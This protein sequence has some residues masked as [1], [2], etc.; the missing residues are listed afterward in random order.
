M[1][2]V[3]IPARLKDLYMHERKWWYG[4]VFK[5]TPVNFQIFITHVNLF[6]FLLKEKKNPSDGSVGDGACR[7]L[8]TVCVRFLGST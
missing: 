7:Q 2:S 6:I 5:Y 1:V 4:F 3:S 8:L